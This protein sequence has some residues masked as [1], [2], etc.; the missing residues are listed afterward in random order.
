MSRKSS[1][2]N[3]NPSITNI[4]TSSA[5]VVNEKIVSSSNLKRPPGRVASYPKQ[6]AQVKRVNHRDHRKPL[7]QQIG[8]D[9]EDTIQATFDRRGRLRVSLDHL[10]FAPIPRSQSYGRGRLPKTSRSRPATVDKSRY[11]NANMKF[12]LDPN[13]DY[14]TSVNEPDEALAWSSIL[15]V[16]TPHVLDSFG[17]PICLDSCPLAP[18]ISRCGHTFCLQCIIRFLHDDNITASAKWNK[19]PICSEPMHLSELK[20]VKFDDNQNIPVAGQDVVLQLLKREHGSILPL[21]KDC[22]YRDRDLAEPLRDI[23]WHFQT[24]A[25]QHARLIRGTKNYIQEELFSEIS[26]LQEN[27]KE[28]NYQDLDVFWN[29]MA[30]A[31]IVELIE[32]AENIDKGSELHSGKHGVSQLTSQFRDISVKNGSNNSSGTYYFYQSKVGSYY[33]LASLDI[34]IL[35]EAFG[36]YS[37]L[38]SNLLVKIERVSDGHI[39]DEELRRRNKVLSHLPLGCQIGFL[40]CDWEG[41]VES[42]VLENFKKDINSRRL[43]RIEKE[44]KEERNKINGERKSDDRK[45]RYC[46]DRMESDY[47]IALDSEQYEDNTDILLGKEPELEQFGI[48]DTAPAR[49]EWP[50]IRSSDSSVGSRSVDWDLHIAP[51]LSQGEK[52]KARKLSQLQKLE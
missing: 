24:E 34:R 4:A 21:A 39:M 10:N 52:K 11:V 12:V 45:A 41:V 37:K 20:P 6:R 43:K 27:A 29:D 35:K 2:P 48:S 44:Q 14:S 26:K 22:L 7:P 17:C 31:N 40:E 46:K 49:P 23:P 15:Q 8:L 19:C 47:N 42:K 28:N 9:P 32:S 16:I 33:F 36:S 3:P 18:R 51:K 30:I 25:V 1:L 50:I 38:P 5:S 13:G